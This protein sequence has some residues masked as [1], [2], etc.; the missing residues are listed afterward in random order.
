MTRSR[1]WRRDR[2]LPNPP[3]LGFHVGSGSSQK[4]WPIDHWIELI[5]QLDGFFGDF[6]LVG[7]EADDK[8]VREFRAR[9]SIYAS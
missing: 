3:T 6:L 1:G 4:N 9:C 8:V 2:N 5:Q 7:G